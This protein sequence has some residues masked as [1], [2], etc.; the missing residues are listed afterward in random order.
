M[1]RFPEDPKAAF[2]LQGHH[3][4]ALLLHGFTGTPYEVRPLAEVFH[5]LGFSVWAP[6]LPGHGDDGA[7]INRT[8]F[9]GWQQ[10]VNTTFQRMRGPGPKWVAGVSMGGLLAT[11]LAARENLDALVLIAPAFELF[12]E[13]KAAVALSF[14][15]AHKIM[16]TIPKAEQGGDIVD[17]EAQIFNPNTPEIPIRG[18]QELEKLRQRALKVLPK[19]K[20]PV[21]IAHGEKDRTIPPRAS[22]HASQALRR[23]KEVIVHRFP[24]SGHVLP[25][26]LEH[27]KVQQALRLF[28]TSQNGVSK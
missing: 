4:Q 18:L 22:V 12:P 8:T 3:G 21:F 16:P 14:L 1:S 9:Q 10:A 20:A 23:S 13:G 17:K 11:C 5:D 2:H 25:I 26:D 24:I 7:A 19:I 6:L 28:V 27:K 15:G